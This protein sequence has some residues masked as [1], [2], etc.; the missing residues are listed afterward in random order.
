[1]LDLKQY[2]ALLASGFTV[3]KCEYCNQYNLNEKEML[4]ANKLAIQ[5]HQFHHV[6]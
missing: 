2:A 1:M 3:I 6:F 4:I 5:A